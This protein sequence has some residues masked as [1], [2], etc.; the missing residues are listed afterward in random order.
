MTRIRLV[1]LGLGLCLGAAGTMSVHAE[2][3]P[4]SFTM[5]DA[6]CEATR[7][8]EVTA[9][10]QDLVKTAALGACVT[11]ES[12]Q[13]QALIA[14]RQP[15]T[16]PLVLIDRSIE[17]HPQFQPLLRSNVIVPITNGYQVAEGRLRVPSGLFLIGQRH[18]PRQLDVFVMALCPFGQ[19]AQ[20]ALAEH[21][22]THQNLPVKVRTH[23]IVNATK[24]GICGLHGE[25]EVTENI[26]QLLIQQRHPDRFWDYLIARLSNK[27]FEQAA[28]AVGLKPAAITKREQHEGVSLLRHDAEL[29]QQLRIGA[30]PTLL[31]ENQYLLG[32]LQ[33][34]KTREGFLDLVIPPQPTG[35]CG[36][37][38]MAVPPIPP[39]TK[40]LQP[41]NSPTPNPT[42]QSAPPAGPQTTYQ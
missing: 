41:A 22:K 15:H 26:R 39:A 30:S 19:T 37:G 40:A 31:W 1:V 17:Q 29:T 27:S 13:G 10:L 6:T 32:S 16:L 42:G 35:R 2:E 9:A 36:A 33:D 20:R 12:A 5:V 38:S 8:Q 18:V 21:L 3:P 11:A 34:L 7:T 28:E 4:A 24:Y 23:Y 14:Q 25:A